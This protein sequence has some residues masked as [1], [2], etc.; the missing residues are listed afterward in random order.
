MAHGTADISLTPSPVGL[1]GR[2][3]LCTWN[4]SGRCCCRQRV[5][6]VS[7]FFIIEVLAI[8]IDVV[9]VSLGI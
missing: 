7:I 9:K 2:R 4:S 1:V 5:W 6:A 8:G 3:R